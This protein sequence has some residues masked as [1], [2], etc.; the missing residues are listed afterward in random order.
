M[1]LSG[2]EDGLN[3][4]KSML[5]NRTV[6]LMHYFDEYG[7]PSREEDPEGPYLPTWQTSP[8][9]E[10]RL[11]NENI[12]RNADEK[13]DVLF[14]MNS[15][16]AVLAPF[17]LAP[18]GEIADSNPRTALF[19]TLMS[20]SEGREVP[21]MGDPVSKLYM[22]LFDKFNASTRQVVGVMSSII[23]WVGFHDTLSFR[24]GPPLIIVFVPPTVRI[25]LEVLLD[26]DTARWRQR[27]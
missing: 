25:L 12:L 1:G 24:F 18:A 2:L 22:P 7:Y 9:L 13:E 10:T 21:Y 23:H 14:L 17:M 19:A 6:D 27:D 16:K 3:A 5:T 15:S 8:Y 11:V 4:R 20:I 26:Q